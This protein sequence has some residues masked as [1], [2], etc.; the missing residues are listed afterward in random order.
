MDRYKLSVEGR[1]RFERMSIKLKMDSESTKI[2]GYEVLDYLFEHG[3]ATVEEIENH[4]GQSWAQ[5]VDKIGAFIYRGYVE[6][7]HEK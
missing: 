2:K 5:V 1:A 7:L 6:K 3:S 4:T